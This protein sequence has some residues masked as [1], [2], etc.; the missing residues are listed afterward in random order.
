MAAVVL[1]VAP[2]VVAMYDCSFCFPS[3]IIDTGNTAWQRDL[4]HRGVS[5][6]SAVTFLLEKFDANGGRVDE[7]LEPSWVRNIWF[8][9]VQTL[10]GKGV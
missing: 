3:L 4:A 5:E 8:A 7:R 9:L 6:E 1:V 10:E 2:L